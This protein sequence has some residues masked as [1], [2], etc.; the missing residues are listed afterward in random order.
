MILDTKAA[1]IILST[2]A[3]CLAMLAAFVAITGWDGASHTVKAQN[4]VAASEIS[5]EPVHQAAPISIPPPKKTPDVKPEISPL[6]KETPVATAELVPLPKESPADEP[7]STLT[8]NET[9]KGTIAVLPGVVVYIDLFPQVA[10]PGQEINISVNAIANTCGIS[11]SEIMLEF[12]PAI[13][14]IAG[15]S[16]DGVLGSNPLVGM[17]EKDNRNGILRYAVARKGRTQITASAETLAGI[18]FRVTD[19]ARSGLYNL[20]LKEVRLT[21]EKFEDITEFEVK[22]GSLEVVP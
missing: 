6:P 17:E 13:L 2:L 10:H 1:K 16:A 21:D 9:T 3:F 19:S 14:Q 15:L 4:P 12:D 11:G 22:S 20:T 8:F 7:E 18:T 5:S